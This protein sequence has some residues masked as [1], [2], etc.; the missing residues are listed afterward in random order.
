[1][2]VYPEEILEKIADILKV[3]AEPTRLKIL[4]IL[5]N[6]E[7]SVTDLHE[8][9][10]GS[11]ANVSKHLGVLKRSGLVK[12]HRDGSSSLYS[13]VD[14]SIFEICDSICHYL[15]KKIEREQKLLKDLG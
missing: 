15:K 4:Q 13:L 14:Q 11:Q 6:G 7:C 2:N 8:A 12:V 10:G 1:M 3:M 9:L 5:K